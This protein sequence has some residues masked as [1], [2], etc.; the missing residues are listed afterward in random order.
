MAAILYTILYRRVLSFVIFQEKSYWLLAVY[1]LASYTF[2]A[3]FAKVL[4]GGIYIL[5]EVATLHTMIILLEQ[6]PLIEF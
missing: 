5:K 6:L 1:K 3:T 4:V 2:T